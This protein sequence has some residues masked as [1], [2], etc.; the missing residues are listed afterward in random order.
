[1]SSFKTFGD[2]CKISIVAKS[3]S[4]FRGKLE[5]FKKRFLTCLK[6]KD[7]FYVI[8]EFILIIILHYSNKH[9]QVNFGLFK[10]LQQGNDLEISQYV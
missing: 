1:M 3:T 7:K 2:A 8:N 4:T 9:L 10:N 5:F 6:D